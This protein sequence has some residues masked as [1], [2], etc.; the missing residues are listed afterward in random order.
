MAEVHLRRITTENEHECLGL[1]VDDAQAKFVAPN[2]QSLAQAKANPKLVPLGVYDRRPAGT[3]T[4]A[5][6]WSAL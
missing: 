1:Q 2:A 6:Q 4:P 5:F 3:P